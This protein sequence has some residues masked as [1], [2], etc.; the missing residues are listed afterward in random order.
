MKKENILKR[1]DQKEAEVKIIQQATHIS[2]QLL[3]LK[4]HLTSGM[5]AASRLIPEAYK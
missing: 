1:K 5:Y 3:Q 2:I 4:F